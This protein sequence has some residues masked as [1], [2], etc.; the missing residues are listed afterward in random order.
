MKSRLQTDEK[1][2]YL[3]NKPLYNNKDKH[4][5]LNGSGLRDK[6]EEDR[7]F[8]FVHRCCHR[9]IHDHP[10]TAK[11]LKMRAQRK[12]EE[13]IGTREEFIKRYGKSYL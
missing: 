10:I 4:H 6:C 8:C 3:C 2:C 12:Y 13:E 1:I 11:T 5:I 7:L 9:Y